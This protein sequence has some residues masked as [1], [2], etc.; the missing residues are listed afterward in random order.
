MSEGAGLG[1]TDD[2]PNLA[3]KVTQLERL[4]QVAA[5]IVPES[6][7]RFD[8]VAEARDQHYRHFRINPSQAIK[9]PVTIH[10]R[11]AKIQQDEA[12]APG[13]IPEQLNALLWTGGRVNVVSFV[14]QPH[15][16]HIKDTDVIVYDENCGMRVPCP[17][18]RPARCFAQRQT[19]DEYR[20]QSNCRDHQK[21]RHNFLAIHQPPEKVFS[22]RNTSLLQQ[23]NR[24]QPAWDRR[25]AG[26]NGI[27][28]AATTTSWKSRGF[29][30]TGIG[31]HCDSEMVVNGEETAR[32]SSINMIADFLLTLP[33][34]DISYSFTQAHLP[35]KVVIGIL[36]VFSIFSWT[37]MFTKFGEIS[38]ARRL[39]KQ[40]LEAFRSEK[41]AF[42]LFSQRVRVEG[43][44]LFEIY[45]AGCKELK[46][47]H[48][49][50]SEPTVAVGLLAPASG[51]RVTLKQM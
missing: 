32:M 29:K 25:R 51:K 17:R 21:R 49:I 42:D 26:R 7:G 3:D 10:H 24:F 33:L 45:T 15:A 35:G 50:E 5:H 19:E 37:V 31:V 12:D 4:E 16:N 11:H 9:H 14:F 1:E 40:F 18:H 27:W 20:N 23:K 22:S 34:A 2:F 8:V 46:N 30:K 36:V 48:G 44:S 39:N 43:C 47:Y 41:S 28:H 13:L 38:R 6:F